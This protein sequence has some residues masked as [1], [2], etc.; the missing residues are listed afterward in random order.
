MTQSDLTRR[1]FV[2]AMTAVTVGL[3][4]CTGGGGSGGTDGD[5][6]GS[7]STPTSTPTSGSE[8]N[9]GD[10][11]TP[12]FDGYLSE[13]SN[14]DG[15]DDRTGQSEVTVDVG[16]EA[17]GGYY[18]FGPAAIR[19]STGTTVVW[20]WTGQG[21]FHNVVAQ[22][23]SFESEQT[24]EAGFTFS[25]TFEEPGTVKYYCAPHETLGMKGVVVV[26]E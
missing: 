19:I 18:D 13:T 14:Y 1:G 25:Q 8:S 15:V 11:S 26:E 4:G 5:S 7:N 17:N 16:V 21:S 6:S 9:G 22:D 23:G 3:A 10:G 2:G 24:D 12:S 20:K